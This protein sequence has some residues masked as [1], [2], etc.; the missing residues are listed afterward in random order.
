MFCTA[1]AF[2]AGYYVHAVQNPGLEDFPILNQAYKILLDHALNDPPT[3]PGLEYGMIRGMLQSYDDPYTI[4]VEPVQHELE[5]NSLEGKFG[6]IGVQLDRDQDGNVIVFPFPDSPAIQAGIR[7]GDQLLEV[8]DLKISADVSIES[9]QAAIRGPEGDSV[10]L[11]IAHPP[12]STPVELSIVRKSIPLPSVTWHLDPGNLQLGVIQVNA[13]AASTPDEIQEAVNDLQTRGGT[14]FVLDLRDNGGGLLSTGV[15]TARLFLR[16]GVIIQ[17]QYRNRGVETYRVENPGPFTE[18]PL[19][20]LVNH[21]TAS[22]AEIIAGALQ[23]HQRAVLVG[24]P[25]FG[26][27]TVQLVFDLEDGSSLHVT[28]G[29][30]WIP[31]LSVSELENGLQPDVILPA[32]EDNPNA[33]VAAASQILFDGQ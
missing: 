11:L 22:A 3:Y 30:W 13:I 28:A 27:D 26:K 7:E 20:I 17:Q 18:V 10:R 5:T 32:E 24:S 9:I 8:E 29:R 33:A 25:T 15:D 31:E 6:G 19:A 23:S 16:E 2:V 21:S 12:D 14:H 1:L 4:F